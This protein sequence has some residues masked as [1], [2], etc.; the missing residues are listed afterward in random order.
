M[1]QPRFERRTGRSPHAL[2][3]HPRFRAGWDFLMLRCES[4]EVPAELGEWW[5]DFSLAD[6]PGRQAMLERAAP[7][8]GA[9]KKRKRRGRR[10]GPADAGEAGSEDPAEPGP[11]SAHDDQRPTRSDA[12]RNDAS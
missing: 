11:P 8:G 4:G 7:S 5:H 1:M 3:A 2:V 6:A 10:K 12:S 9:A